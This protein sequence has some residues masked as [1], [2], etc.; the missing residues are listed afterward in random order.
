MNFKCQK[1]K[2]VGD[3]AQWQ[4]SSRIWISD[5]GI[6]N[7]APVARARQR[8][9]ARE[10]LV[11]RRRGLPSG[12]QDNQ[13]TIGMRE[14]SAFPVGPPSWKAIDIFRALSTDGRV[15]HFA[16]VVCS[17]LSVGRSVAAAAAAATNGECRPRGRPRRGRPP[18]L[19][20][21]PAPR[22]V[23]PAGCAA[24][25]SLANCLISPQIASTATSPAPVNTR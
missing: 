9:R 10:A 2:Q 5:F 18:R 14:K 6:W 21:S 7:L 22:R 12:S 15:L 8:E 24:I 23:G 25:S 13:I 1:E 3:A 16:F 17:L 11:V 4:R 20:P 19:A